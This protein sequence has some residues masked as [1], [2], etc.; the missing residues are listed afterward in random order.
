MQNHTTGRSNEVIKDV[1]TVCWAWGGKEVDEN[2]KSALAKQS[3]DRQTGG[4]RYFVKRATEGPD[5]GL[6]WNPQGPMFNATR[7]RYEFR[8]ATPEAFAFFMAF[9]KTQ[10]PN[11]IRHAERVS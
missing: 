3:T 9:L 6:M 11:S 1:D 2:D 4:K 10:N 7:S 5:A 8:Q